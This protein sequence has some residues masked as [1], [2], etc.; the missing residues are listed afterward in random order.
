MIC[1]VCGRTIEN[2]TANFCDYCGAS[3]K[4]IQNGSMPNLIPVSQQREEGPEPAAQQQEVSFRNWFS[5]MLLPLIPLVGWIVYLVMLFVWAFGNTAPKSKRNWARASL[6][7]TAIGIFLF[8]YFFSTAFMDMM[9]QYPE[10]KS[11]YFK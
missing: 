11:I 3:L 9:N 7:I 2:E 8:L 1:R 5:S 10:L 6:I 4:E